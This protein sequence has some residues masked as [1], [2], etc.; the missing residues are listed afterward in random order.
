LEKRVG[1]YKSGKRTVAKELYMN[2]S[3]FVGVLAIVLF[4]T[5]TIRAEVQVSMCTIQGFLQIGEKFNPAAA[6]ENGLHG[7]PSSFSQVYYLQLPTPLGKQLQAQ[8]IEVNDENQLEIYS[9]M[10]DVGW[11]SNDAS[12]NPYGLNK[13]VGLKLK[14]S[15]K[16]YS[17]YRAFRQYLSPIFMNAKHVE[18]LE[19]FETSGW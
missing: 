6:P 8:G 18:V 12:Y 1:Y 16:L 4:G 9:R 15:G 3:I 19:K 2:R 11:P 10:V 14:V 5:S 17:P 13:K 7:V